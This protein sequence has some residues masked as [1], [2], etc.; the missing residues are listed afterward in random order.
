MV[1]VDT[2]SALHVVLFREMLLPAGAVRAAANVHILILSIQFIDE[3]TAGAN[4]GC[5]RL[6]VNTTPLLRMSCARPLALATLV[7]DGIVEST[8]HLRF[9]ALLP[10]GFCTFFIQ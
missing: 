2:T 4:K 6:T 9:F 10:A 1:N 5:V 8:I 7:L 3:R